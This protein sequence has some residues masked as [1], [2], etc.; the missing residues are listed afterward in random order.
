MGS[1]RSGEDTGC[2]Y[3]NH[4]PFSWGTVENGVYGP[5]L[6]PIKKGI[7]LAF[8]PSLS[9]SIPVGSGI[10]PRSLS[11]RAFW[12]QSG[13]YLVGSWVLDGYCLVVDDITGVRSCAPDF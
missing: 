11:E 2:A 3:T 12:A 7:V 5:G 8:L 1:A 6:P 10:L 9:T 13:S 4:P